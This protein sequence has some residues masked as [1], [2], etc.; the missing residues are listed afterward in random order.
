M[1]KRVCRYCG[2]LFTNPHRK[3]DWK[4]DDTGQTNFH[5]S[6]FKQEHVMLCHTIEVDEGESDFN[7]AMKAMN[8]AY[9]KAKK[10]ID[11]IWASSKRYQYY[12][13][14]SNDGS[15][16]G[17]VRGGSIDLRDIFNRGVIDLYCK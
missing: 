4:S 2:S 16:V 3:V 11:K 7:I 10:R 5:C 1:I 6:T 17:F 8:K 13:E 14:S 15:S 9:K 12:D